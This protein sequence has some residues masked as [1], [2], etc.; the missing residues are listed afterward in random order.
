MEVAILD[1]TRLLNV[2]SVLLFVVFIWVLA[3]VRR[4]RIRVEYSVSWLL[5]SGLL[6][7]L[8]RWTSLMAWLAVETGTGHSAFSIILLAGAVFVIVLYRLS[9]RISGLMDANIKLTQR[10]AILQMRLESL[11]EKDE[12]SPAR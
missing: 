3:S 2:I 10:V 1:S 4:E 6:F 11:H 12:A 9:I 7:V 8:S 5:G